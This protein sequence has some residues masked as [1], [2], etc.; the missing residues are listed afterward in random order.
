MV[1]GIVVHLS[2]K[3]EV[4]RRDLLYKNIEGDGLPCIKIYDLPGS[5]A[6]MP[7]FRYRKRRSCFFHART[8]EGKAHGA[9][10]QPEGYGPV[11]HHVFVSPQQQMA[12]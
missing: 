3:Y 6:P 8:S 2:Y 11:E 1:I 4:L 7:V 10:D 12:C 9:N 5:K